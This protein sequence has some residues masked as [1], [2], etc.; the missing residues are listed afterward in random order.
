MARECKSS[1]AARY[2]P[3]AREPA[4]APARESRRDARRCS[5]LCALR[6]RALAA[7]RAASRTT[8][9][10][11]GRRQHQVALQPVPP[12]RRA[13]LRASPGLGDG[14]RDRGLP[15]DGA[16]QRPRPAR[17]AG[18]RGRRRAAPSASSCSA[19]P[20]PS[21][22]ASRTTRPSPRCSRR[23]L[24]PPPGFERVEVLNAGVAGWSADQYLLFLETRGFAL[25][26]D[27]VLLAVTENDPGDLAWNRLELDARRLPVRAAADAAHDR[28]ERAA[29]DTSRA[30]RSRSPPSRS[31]A[32]PGSPT[33]PSL[34]HWLRYR[35]AKLW[36]ARALRG[37]ERRCAP[38]RARRPSEPIETLSPDAIQRGLWSGP[39][40][41][42]R[43]HRYLM[44]AIRGACAE[45]GVALATLLVN[46][47]ASQAD[48]GEL[49]TALRADCAADAACVSSGALLAGHGEPEVF[50]AEDGHW[51]RARPRP[52]RRRARALARAA[53][54][55]D[56]V[57]YRAPG[58]TPSKGQRPSNFGSRRSTKALHAFL[59]VLAAEERQELQE[60]VVHVRLEGLVEGHA[61][62]ALRRLHGERRVRRDLLGQRA[63]LLLEELV[64]ARRG[65]RGRARGTPPRRACGPVKAISRRLRPADE[66]R[67]QPGA[68]AL[69][70]H[71]ALREG[72]R[73][74]SRVSAA[75]RMS[76][77]SARSM[78]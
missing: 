4:E 50:F 8:R 78:P 44:D 39:A 15:G 21:A 70:Q 75:M 67:Q 71:A 72:R 13:R 60:D 49:P 61:H 65:S 46:F 41:Q 14:A 24:A 58:Q 47:R 68:A 10:L 37:E 17:R 35:L 32:R 36:I 11:P 26:P 74:A 27:L 7:H 34:Y 77:P 1:R 53:A 48:T 3:R 63:H 33:T 22:S 28:P 52:R 40:F 42:I 23:A 29:C 16:H 18:E 57:S 59:E 54:A 51:T 66:A 31:R 6:R 2:A 12:G 43:Y 69:G 64:R 9:A 56:A 38:R 73:R 19:T 55:L 20:S 62:H 76:Q 30:V 25:A 45:R 5:L